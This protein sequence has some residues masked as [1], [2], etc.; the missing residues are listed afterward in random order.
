MIGISNKVIK[1]ILIGCIL[2]LAHNTPI[3]LTA[4]TDGGCINGLVKVKINDGSTDSDVC[5]DPTDPLM[6]TWDCD[7]YT[8]SALTTSSTTFTCVCSTGKTLS[9]R[10]LDA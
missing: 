2:V 8:T 6:D 9:N 4:L 3:T 7:K 1:L 10:A 5:V